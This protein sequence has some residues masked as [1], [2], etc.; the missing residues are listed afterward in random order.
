MTDG[1]PPPFEI[2]VKAYFNQDWDLEGATAREVVES[3]ATRSS[4]ADVVAA[5]DG[6]ADLLASASDE[7]EL[8]AA[9]DELGLEYDPDY[10]DLTHRGWLQLVVDRLTVWLEHTP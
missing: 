10:E 3:F 2:L 7:A 4:R 1:F 5:R 8:V 6:A 9:L